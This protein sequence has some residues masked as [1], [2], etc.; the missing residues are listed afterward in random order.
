[1]WGRIALS[2]RRRG[3]L[4]WGIECVVD[5]GRVISLLFNGRGMRG[6]S[7]QVFWRA[8]TSQMA[9]VR[10]RRRRDHSGGERHRGETEVTG[11]ENG[12]T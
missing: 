7:A 1:V 6:V 12:Q 11:S 4:R 9:L 8:S 3:Q 10:L 5:I 2:W